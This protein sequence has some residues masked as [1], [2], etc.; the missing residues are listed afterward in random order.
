L[1]DLATTL[2]PHPT[3]SEML[4]EAARTALTKLSCG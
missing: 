4:T 2:R 1:Y 3:R